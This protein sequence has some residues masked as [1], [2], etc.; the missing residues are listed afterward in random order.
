MRKPVWTP[1]DDRV[2]Q[3]NITQ[4]INFV[5]KK[6]HQR[7][8]SYDQLYKWSVENIPEFWAAMWEFGDV[9][10]SRIYDEVV[11]DLGKFP[12]AKW[13]VGSKLNFAENLSRYRD[14]HLAFIFKAEARTSVRMTYAQ[15][16]D[17]VAR[18]AKSLREIGVAAHDR[19][20]AYMPNT[21]ETAISML[22]ST[23]IGAIW[24]SCGTELGPRAVIDR[25][26][27]I[28]PKILFTVAGYPY[29]GRKFN[30]LANVREI[31]KA[32][33]SLEKVVV[34]PYLED[35][36]N[37]SEIPNAILHSD[38]ISKE[39]PSSILF[40]QLPFNHPVYIMFSSG[41]TGKPKCMVQGAGGILINHLKELILH[42]DVKREDRI[43]YIATP[44][45]MMWNW[46]L[47]SLAIGATVIL[48]DG[49]PN[50]PNWRTM[51]KLVQEERMTILGCSA[52]YIN[53]LRSEGAKPGETHNLS[54][55]R[56]ISQTGSPL[57]ADGFEYVYN[58]IKKDLHFNSISGGTDINGCF[59][60]GSPIQP[61]YAGELQGPAL[62]MKIAAYDE[63]GIA[64]LDKQAELVCEA[65]SPSMPL[66]FWN[67]PDGRRYGDAYFSVYPSIWR[68]GDWIIIHSDTGGITFLGRSDFTLKP[69]GVRIGPAEVY[70]VVEKFEEVADSIV[71][72]QNW[73]GDQRIILFVKPAPGFRVTADLRAEITRALRK[74]AS[75]RHVPALIIEVPDV[76]YTFSMKKVESAVSNIMHGKPVTNRDALINPESLDFYEKTLNELQK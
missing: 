71:V 4:F 68:H 17:S 2:E 73:K 49:N 16:F 30:T 44:S 51:W 18:L 5:N 70:N 58:E 46:L 41:T 14:D 47:S 19:V 39:S 55:L 74:Q 60:A 42:T 31:A 3:A 20:A 15:L 24:S 1:S 72:G 21:A 76:P 29:K 64:V 32:I 11:D 8:E 65:P 66:Y 61:V 52:T 9:K 62:A 37:I 69:S 25:F 23:S 57:S 13:F 7:I 33:P 59:A 10:A 22:A 67:D 6:H 48:Y 75:P 45:W 27:Q 53:Y 36:P 34:F 43:F 35:D 56:E 54:S 50:Y 12:G 38:F 40:K 63:R 28:D 26:G